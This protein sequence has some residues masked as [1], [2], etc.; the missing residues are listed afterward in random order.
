MSHASSQVDAFEHLDEESFF[1]RFS[2]DLNAANE[3]VFALAPYFGEY[4]WP[5]I[6]PLFASA[7]SRGVKVTIVTPP[8]MEVQNKSYVEK[9]VTHLRGIGAVVVTASGLHGK[10]V[11]IDEHIVYTGSMNWSSNRG[12]SEEIHRLLA[13]DYAKICLNL[14]QAK[15]IRQ[16]AV[17]EDG[18]SAF[19]SRMRSCNSSR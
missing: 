16:A 19:V 4:R 13:P 2:I 18:S 12:R 8:L 14:L 17:H 5:R 15:H 1:N 6:E 9:V 10:D 7:L 3:S 11:I